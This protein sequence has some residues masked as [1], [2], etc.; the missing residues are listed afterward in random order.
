V[1]DSQCNAAEAMLYWKLLYGE[2]KKSTPAKMVARREEL[3]TLMQ[4]DLPIVCF[5]DGRRM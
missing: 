2:T 1:L 3:G 5:V 4:M